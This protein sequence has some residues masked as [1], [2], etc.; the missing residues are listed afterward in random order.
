[1]RYLRLRELK[2]LPKGSAA[3]APHHSDFTALKA[4]MGSL[5]GSGEGEA[6]TLG[7]NSG[8]LTQGSWEMRDPLPLNLEQQIGLTQSGG[9]PSV[10]L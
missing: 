4:T 7:M 5:T 3:C 10:P 8:C 6:G 2:K 9:V 1:M